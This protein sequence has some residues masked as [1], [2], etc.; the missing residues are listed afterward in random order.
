MRLT[1][2]SDDRALGGLQPVEFPL[3][4]GNGL[5]GNQLFF[6]SVHDFQIIA[7]EEA[8]FCSLNPEVGV[9]LSD[10][11]FRSRMKKFSKCAIYECKAA[12]TILGENEIRIDV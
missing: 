1:V 9:S 11:S 6:Q 5:F 7:T 3:R 10:E 4:I 2:L 12:L 8:H